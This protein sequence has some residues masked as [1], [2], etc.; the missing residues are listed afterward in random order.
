MARDHY[1]SMFLHS[2]SHS[3]FGFQASFLRRAAAALRYKRCSGLVPFLT[4]VAS[5]FLLAP[6]METEQN[7]DEVLSRLSRTTR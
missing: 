7:L 5:G 4:S 1:A 3:G 6:A 2:S